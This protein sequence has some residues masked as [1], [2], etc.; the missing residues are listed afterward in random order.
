MFVGYLN[1]GEK[2]IFQRRYFEHTIIDE[3]DLNN[4][5]NHIRELYPEKWTIN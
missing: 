2:G 5:I 3:K 4:Q 1:K